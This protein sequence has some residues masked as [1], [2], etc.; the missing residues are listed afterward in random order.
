[1]LSPQNPR[2]CALRGSPESASAPD[3]RLFWIARGPA[4][5]YS[6]FEAATRLETVMFLFTDLHH[7]STLI[8]TNYG[9][10]LILT[11]TLLT[12]LQ[13][14]GSFPAAP[15]A[16]VL[17]SVRAESLSRCTHP[18]TCGQCWCSCSRLLQCPLQRRVSKPRR[19]ST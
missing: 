10:N 5:V 7:S 13:N 19:A 12:G 17:R 9:N 16:G 3:T 18:L 14:Y 11:K 6:A 15:P 8:L 1:M 2:G 4:W